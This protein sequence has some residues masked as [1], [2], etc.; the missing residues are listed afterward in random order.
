MTS[1]LLIPCNKITLLR[2]VVFMSLSNS[3]AI[4]VGQCSAL[5]SCEKEGGFEIDKDEE[6]S[7]NSKNLKGF[8]TERE[9][10]MNSMRESV[11]PYL[12]E[13]PAVLL[14]LGP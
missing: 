8:L 5:G 13:Y 4:G 12:Q 10:S 6:G 9:D 11:T 3:L 14:G 1:L 2:R 7:I